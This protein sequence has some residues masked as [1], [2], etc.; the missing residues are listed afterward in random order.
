M[1]Q[2]LT[3]N[4]N[5]SPA[6]QDALPE[7]PLREATFRP[8][9]LSRGPEHD[10]PSRAASFRPREE[11]AQRLDALEDF[12]AKSREDIVLDVV[13]PH[14]RAELLLSKALV[15]EATGQ[16]EAAASTLQE[17]RARQGLDARGWRIMRRIARAMHDASLIDTALSHSAKA[18]PPI[19]LALVTLE[20][21]SRQWSRG[22]PRELVALGCSELGRRLKQDADDPHAS[23]LIDWWRASLLVDAA[24]SS[25]DLVGALETLEELDLTHTADPVRRVTL[26]LRALLARAIGEPARA[27]A[28]LEPLR[29]DRELD[30]SL[31]GLMFALLDDARRAQEARDWLPPGAP[32][33][34]ADA[35]RVAY[36]AHTQGADFEV[37]EAYLAGAHDH[38]PLALEVRAEAL[39]AAL[40]AGDEGA[41]ERLIHVLNLRLEAAPEDTPA[42][43]RVAILLRLGSLYELH[44]NLDHA[45]AE[46]YREAKALDPTHASVLR[47]LGRVYARRGDWHLLTTL[48]EHEIANQPASAMNWR[49]HYQVAELYERRL[50]DPSRALEH[51][52]KVL[53]LRPNFLPA[54]KACARLME[55]AGQWSA[56]ADLFLTMVPVTPSKRQRLYLL[57]KVAEIAEH[58]LKNLDVAAG[59]WREMLEMV[60]DHPTAYASLGRLYAKLERWEDLLALNADEMVLIEDGA[61]RATLAQRNAEICLNHMHDPCGAQDWL[62]RALADAPDH[63]PALEALGRLLASEGRWDEIAMMWRDEF[64]VVADPEEQLRQLDVV[65]E[66]CARKL[67]RPEDAIALYEEVLRRMPTYDQA[68]HE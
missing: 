36:A 46:V 33:Y 57:D 35:V 9:S 53:K 67:G 31:R 12:L 68:H 18:E 2:R 38:D 61:E 63:L 23:A 55:R 6:G 54:V 65:A 32:A 24:L 39:E 64:S 13:P 59:A 8:P 49:R 7:A 1:A 15:E 20:T 43:E 14:W 10:A 17:L 51:Y 21:I 28:H 50:E 40:E 16:L 37:V 27:L 26:V 47:A 22:A 58:R 5:E 62:R 11:V 60:P 30:P 29:A 48:F 45:A 44:A 52:G 66:M 25:S 19:S 56:L 41:A 4:Q 34:A 42:H 3:P